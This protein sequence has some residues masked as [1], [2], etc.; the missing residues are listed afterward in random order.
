MKQLKMFF[1]LTILLSVAFACQKD[2]VNP[3]IDEVAISQQETLAEETLA[4]IDLMVDEA[5]DANFLL[6]KSATIDNAYLGDCPVVT[7]NKTSNPQMMTIDFGTSCTGKD[8]KVRSGKI[9]VTSASFTTFPSVRDKS[10]ENYTIDGKKI[11]GSVTKTISKDQE[12]NI[13]TAVISENVTITFPDGEGT[14]TRKANQTRQY[15]RNKVLNPA[16]NQ[17]V[18]WGTVEFT[19]VSGVKVTKIVTSDKPLVFKVAC[20]HMVSGV[21]SVSTS[22]SQS[23]TIDFGDGTCD[24]K[25]LLTKNGETKEI[26]IK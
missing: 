21:V 11:E 20:H 4:D 5:L 9:I 22:N 14:A 7:V 12:N 23:W 3:A 1:A 15:Q 24:N 18:S 13:R 6:L 16:D 19:R 25:A 26:K 10:F 8:G 17:V 2:E